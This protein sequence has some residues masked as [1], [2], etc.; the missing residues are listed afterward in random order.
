MAEQFASIAA[1]SEHK[2]RN[3][4]YK[5]LLDSFVSKQSAKDLKAFFEHSRSQFLLTFSVRR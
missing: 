3:E 2:T 1:I 4:K 5:S